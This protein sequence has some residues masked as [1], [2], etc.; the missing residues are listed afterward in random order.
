M[1]VE[2]GLFKPACLRAELVKR[3]CK[4]KV[5]FGQVLTVCRNV[6]CEVGRFGE[7]C[8]VWVLT[9]HAGV[10]SQVG[11]AIHTGD[12]ML[13][14]V[15]HGGQIAFVRIQYWQPPGLQSHKAAQYTNTAQTSCER[16]Y[17]QVSCKLDLL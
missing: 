9:Q 3:S 10:Y 15:T 11:D 6:L 14:N 8:D 17:W 5:Q 13:K 12:T 1:P 7:I 2:S 4:S 16:Q